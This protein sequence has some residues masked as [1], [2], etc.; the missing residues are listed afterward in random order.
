MI[1]SIINSYRHHAGV[2][3]ETAPH[4]EPPNPEPAMG[5]CSKEAA[6]PAPS[7]GSTENPNTKEKEKPD[8]DTEN[9]VTPKKLNNINESGEPISDDSSSSNSDDSNEDEEGEEEEEVEN[10]ALG[11]RANYV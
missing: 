6:N 11:I 8:T 3:P 1:P 5:P 2:W 4:Q 10:Q 7:S 9:L